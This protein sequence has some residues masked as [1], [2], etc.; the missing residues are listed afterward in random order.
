MQHGLV[1][2][3]AGIE[4]WILI[5]L[6][7][8]PA[9]AG[10][11]KKTKKEQQDQRRIDEGGASLELEEMAAK[12]R[13]QLRQA[14]QQRAQANL[15]GGGSTGGQASG[16]GASPG[17]MTM[18]ER[19]AR[20]RAKAQYEQ[21]A[22]SGLQQGGASQPQV[23]NEAQRRALE[24]RQ[25]ELQRRRE[26]AARQQQRA[27]QQQAQAQQRARQRAQQQARQ[28][29]AQAQ[30]RAQARARQRGQLV[31]ESVVVP[32]PT[33]SKTRRLVPSEPKPKPRQTSAQP[34]AGSRRPVSILGGRMTRDE[35]RRAIVMNEV[36]G[37]PLALRGNGGWS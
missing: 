17:N 2:T 13:E 4:S 28:R 14:S 8:A 24:Q 11:I 23:P 36:L 10:W 37:K 25:A 35:L 18:A 1:L 9:I 31:H 16:G 27:Q 22:Q 19:I 15:S 7:L 20:A 34:V 3:L 33:E 6:L 12:R 32:D 5:A 29:Q 30:S 26:A 21:R